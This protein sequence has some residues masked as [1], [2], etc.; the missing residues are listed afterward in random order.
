MI[1]QSCRLELGNYSGPMDLLL[2]L[3]RRSELDVL[4]IEISKIT[5]QFDEFLEI[6]ELVDLDV[7]GDFIVMAATLVEIKSRMV[8]PQ[9]QE[10]EEEEAE[11]VSNEHIDP[12]TD[13]VKQLIEYKR[14][15]DASEALEEH[16]AQWQ[17]RYPRLHVERPTGGRNHAA[18][19]IKDVELWDLV[20]ALARIV[21]QKHVEEKSSI[22]YDET[23]IHLYIKEIGALVR[24]EKEVS[25][26][27][28]FEGAYDKSRIVRKFLAV[29]ELL[30]HYQFRA[31]QKVDYGDIMIYPPLAESDDDM[32]DQPEVI[33]ELPAELFDEE[34]Q[35]ELDDEN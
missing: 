21:K 20:S 24:K 7:V 34:I 33:P 28:L 29:L 19:L 10:V 14:F 30:R 1:A 31:Y 8:L 27:S 17:D 12:R 6:L 16:A 22:S 32:G 23:P 9:A 3:V 35:A 18:D 15:K 13:L 2:Y 4:D 26:N 11:D 5:S 25:F